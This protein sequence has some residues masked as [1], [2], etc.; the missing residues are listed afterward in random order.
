MEKALRKWSIIG[1]FVIIALAGFWH[2]LYDLLPCGL[3]AAISPVNESPWEHAKLFFVPAIIWYVIMYFAV[4]NAFPNY[5][6]AH[7][8]A[9]L[10]M[11]VF[12]LLFYTLYS[13]FLEETFVFD[14]IN[15]VHHDR[16]GVVCRL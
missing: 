16:A 3:T 1:V 13:S 7:S 2:F 4:G 6:F 12:M 5:I 11:P 15:S 8:I 14:M 10:I 9:L